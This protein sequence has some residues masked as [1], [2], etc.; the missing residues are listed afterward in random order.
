LVKPLGESRVHEAEFSQPLCAAI[1]IVLVNSLQH[2][3]I[4]PEVAI[5]HSS[6]EIAAAYAVGILSLREAITI[7]YYRGL[8]T[9]NLPQAGGM[10]AIGLGASAVEPFLNAGTTIAAEN[11]P[12]STTVSGDVKAIEQLVSTIQQANQDVFAR[13][14]KV[15]MAYHSSE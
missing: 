13:K 9:K 8:A 11:S 12:A 5:G 15:D 10:A 6:G 7:S 14:L 1:Q 4:Y 2:A 3:D